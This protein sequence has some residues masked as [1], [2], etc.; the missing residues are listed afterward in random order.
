MNHIKLKQAAI[1]IS[2]ILHPMIVAPVM[3]SIL[4]YT[5]QS[6]QN[7]NHL[8]ITSFLFST[9]FPVATIFFFKKKNLISDLEVSIREQRIQ[10]LV[11]GTIY[12]AIGFILL[13]LQNATPLIQGIMFCY[14]INTAI[15]WFITR[16]WKISIHAIGL[17][18][19]LVALW[20]NG[21]NHPIIMGLLL[22]LVCSARVI[23]DAHT[24]AQVILGAILAIV[25][26][27]FELTCLFIL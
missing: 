27:Y 2:F 14:A 9:F 8:F 6:I 1:I 5:D 26:A 7:A 3:F 10:P 21:F 16:I 22:F 11:F 20:L 25:L 12:F 24:P 18:G 19:P 23:M 13:R 15:V 4:I 17:G